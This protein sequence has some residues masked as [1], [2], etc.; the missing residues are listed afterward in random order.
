MTLRQIRHLSRGVTG[1]GWLL[2]VAGLDF[3]TLW[4]K[5][6][7][8]AVAAIGILLS[9]TYLR[10]PHCKGQIQDLKAKFCAYCG[11]AIDYDA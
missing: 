7:G 4:P 3:E 1:A 5:V 8:V 6:V 2:L 11:K 9:W 10:C